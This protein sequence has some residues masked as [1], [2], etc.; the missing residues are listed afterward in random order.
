M[1]RNF[2]RE[3]C[4]GC[5]NCIASCP[6]Q[7]LALSEKS[8]QGDKRYAVLKNAEDCI[9]CGRCAVMC[10]AGA[11]WMS[12]ER[13]ETFRTLLKLNE[14]P[15]HAGCALGILGRIMAEAIREKGIEDRT[16][17]FK[18]P[19]A[20]INLKCETYSMP[21]PEYFEEAIRYKEKNPEKVVLVIFSDAKAPMHQIAAKRF[22]E[23]REEK[24]TIIHT[25]DFFAQKDNYQSAE[26]CAE[27][28]LSK[29][30]KKT[31]AGFLAR[32]SVKTPEE[33]G[34]LKEY[35]RTALTRQMEGK[36]FSIVE[37]IYPCYYRLEGR[38]K[39]EIPYERLQTVKQ[40][41]EA[42]VAPGFKMGILQKGE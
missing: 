36:P 26:P 21:A 32:G 10:T 22:P 28:I 38:P 42:F 30:E 4:T 17:I 3:Q 16:V 31:G 11:V 29:V 27:D 7:L 5:G 18:S 20:E 19:K 1:V 24:I 9:G 8:I 15:G 35:I 34:K 25:L 39:E 33:V 41:F 13:E 23:L 40:W 37:I 2:S 14:L 6:G 12:K